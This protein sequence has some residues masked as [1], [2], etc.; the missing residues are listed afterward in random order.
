MAALSGPGVSSVQRIW[1]AHGLR[2][3][4][5]RRFKLSSDP[6]F[7]SKLEDIVGLDVDPPRHA[8]VLSVDEKA[9]GPQEKS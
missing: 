9:P 7:A 2:P 1:R 3:H 6:N 4:Q 8:V 5:V